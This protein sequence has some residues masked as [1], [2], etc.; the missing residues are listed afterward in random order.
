[1]A[2]VNP[3]YIGMKKK[4]HWNY[5]EI[6]GLRFNIF[7]FFSGIELKKEPEESA[8]ASSRDQQAVKS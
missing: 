7:A 5:D 6:S 4:K 3:E 8:A 2:I 1:M